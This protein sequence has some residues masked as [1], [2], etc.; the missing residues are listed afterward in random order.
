[1]TINLGI[2]LDYPV[3]WDF[4]MILRDLIQNFYDEVDYHQ[5]GKEFRYSYTEENSTYTLEMELRG[6]PFPG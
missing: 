3:N 2:A 4:E 5:F 6:H 1:M